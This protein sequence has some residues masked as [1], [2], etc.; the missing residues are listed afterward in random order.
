MQTRIIRILSC[1]VVLPATIRLCLGTDGWEIVVGRHASAVEHYA[2]A[3]LQRYLYQLSGTLFR[4]N[5]KRPATGNPPWSLGKCEPTPC[6][7]D[8]SARAN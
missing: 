7:S 1:R 5:R 2:A 8:W 3:E 6:S 4:S